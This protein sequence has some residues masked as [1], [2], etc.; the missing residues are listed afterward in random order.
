MMSAERVRNMV[1]LS[2]DTTA[3]TASVCVSEIKDGVH[4]PLYEASINGTLTHS[5][6]LLPMTDEALRFSHKSLDEVDV[7]AVST[8]PGSFTGV[9]IGVAAAKGLSFAMKNSHVCIPVSSLEG[10]ANNLRLATGENTVI[11]PVMDARRSQ[12]YNALFSFDGTAMKRL[13]EDRLVTAEELRTELCAEYKGKRVLLVGDGAFVA[14]SV[15]DRAQDNAFTYETVSGGLIFQNAFSVAVAALDHADKWCDG[16][17]KPKAEEYG[18]KT[19]SP[20][21]L[22]ASQAERERNEKCGASEK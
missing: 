5:E 16:D 6:T 3:K 22:R 21:Y 9:R 20:T 10:L 7:I 8:G 1:L 14:K 17:G 19:L 12:V 4:L 18:G 2:M 11:C 13:C 15:F